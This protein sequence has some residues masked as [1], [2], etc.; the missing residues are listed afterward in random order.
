M[1]RCAAGDDGA[2]AAAACDEGGHGDGS[3]GNAQPPQHCQVCVAV[4]RS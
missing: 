1:L 2:E 4:L 3:A